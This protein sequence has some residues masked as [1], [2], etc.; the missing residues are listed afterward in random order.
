MVQ[1]AAFPSGGDPP[2][3]YGAS[4]REGRE[5]R[6]RH[7]VGGAAARRADQPPFS[8]APEPLFDGDS[9]VPRDLA[10]QCRRHVTTSVKEDCRASAVGVPLLAMRASLPD[11]P[12][13]KAFRQRSEFARFQDRDGARGLRDLD[14]L[15]AHELGLELGFAVLE[16]HGDDFTQVLL[17]FV[18]RGALAVRSR[19]SWNRADEETR[20]RVALDHDVRRSDAM[21]S[22]SAAHEW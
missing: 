7:P 21:A 8:L 4:A 22:G 11:L 12:K 15:E 17:E 5:R 13:A 6:P 9:D 18:E 2:K 19:P 14:G 10:Q 3:P 1:R 20:I 16:Q